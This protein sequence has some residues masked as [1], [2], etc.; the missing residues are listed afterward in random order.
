MKYDVVIIGG[1]IIGTITARE[2]SKYRLDICVLEA[3]NH[4]AG[5]TSEGNS[6]V[7]HV[8]FDATPGTLKAKFNIKGRLLWFNEIF[9]VIE[10]KKI[11]IPTLVIAMEYH[12]SKQL[13]QIGSFENINLKDEMNHLKLLYDRGIKNN[14]DSSE[15]MILNRDQ[16][17]RVEPHVSP[18][19]KGA[20]FAPN[21]WIINTPEV[22]K[23]LMINAITNG[24]DLKF[25]K[26]VVDIEFIKGEFWLKTQDGDTIISKYIV[27][28]AGHYA[29]VLSKLANVD[30]FTQTTRRGEYRVLAKTESQYIN[31]IIFKIPTIFGKGVIVAPMLTGHVLVGPTALNGVPKQDTRLVTQDMYKHIGDIGHDMVP[32]LRLHKTERTFAGSRPICVE[33]N[34]FVIRHS[35][36]NKQF[37]ILGGMQS[38]A[39][40]SAPAIAKKAI[41][42]LEKSGLKLRKKANFNPVYKTVIPTIV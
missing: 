36:K 42:L 14:L 23:A 30:D 39:I 25:K 35:K 8:G 2:L 4:L 27:N 41:L 21:T 34:D 31:N 32:S 20:L 9:P 19:V 38:P 22:T 18:L 40:A 5:E 15:M 33:T 6:G 28:A 11:K 7:I 24:V 10:F 16:T 37:V 12:T 29:D 1:G 26:K 13:A 3:N 17:H